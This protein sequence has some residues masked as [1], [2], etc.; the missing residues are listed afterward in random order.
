ML[1]YASVK[2]GSRIPAN[3]F[4][5]GLFSLRRR[6]RRSSGVSFS[7]ILV[8]D[9]RLRRAFGETGSATSLDH[10]SLDKGDVD[11]LLTLGRSSQITFNVSKIC[12]R[13]L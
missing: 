7:S 3:R 5:A 6:R 11:L 1:V 8:V 4:N 2:V 10:K 13:G 12:S 9:E